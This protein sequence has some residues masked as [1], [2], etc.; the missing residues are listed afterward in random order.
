MI[1]I[2]DHNPSRRPAYVTWA[3]I[4]VSVAVFAYQSSLGDAGTLHFFDAWATV[5][6]RI[7]A[8]EGLVG[9]LTSMFLHAD[10]WHLAGNMLFLWIFGDNVED[11]LGHVGFLAFYLAC[12]ALSALAQVAT[13]PTDLIP[14]VGASG[15]IAGVMG[16]Y[17]LFFPR[18]RIDILIFLVVI[19][20][21]LPIPA[22]LMLAV[23]GAM[24]VINGLG[25]EAGGGGVAYWAHAGG[26]VAGIAIALPIWLRRGGRAFWR[27]T[28]GHPDHPPTAAPVTWRATTVPRVG[29]R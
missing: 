26:M 29:R 8:G 16:A 18:A 13:A 6:S 22:W 25:T 21:I 14:L 23:W 10:L 5:P 28:E 12:G 9:L 20:R 4:A 19:V 17:L 2:R 27:R 24:Q 11:E 15:A 1:P 7:S 3:L